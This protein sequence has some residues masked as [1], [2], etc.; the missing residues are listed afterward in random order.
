MHGF[1]A[2]TYFLS[3]DFV[4]H[5]LYSECTRLTLAACLRDAHRTEG[6]PNCGAYFPVSFLRGT[7]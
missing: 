2:S 5:L 7:T 6:F 3:S 4:A 1:Y